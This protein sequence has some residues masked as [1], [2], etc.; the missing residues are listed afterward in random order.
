MFQLKY[1]DWQ[2]KLKKQMCAVYKRENILGH[3]NDES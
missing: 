2:T 1:K 3:R